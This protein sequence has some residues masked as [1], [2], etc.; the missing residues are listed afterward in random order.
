M[1]DLKDLLDRIHIS[2]KK[3]QEQNLPEIERDILLDDLRVLYA[4]L[5]QTDVVAKK[6]IEMATI[7]PQDTIKEEV[8]E[9]E[10]KEEIIAQEPV[11]SPPLRLQEE[12]IISVEEVIHPRQIKIPETQ[13]KVAMPLNEIFSAKEQSLNEKLSPVELKKALNDQVV[14]NDLKSLIDFNKQIAITRELFGGDAAAYALAISKINSLS[15]IQQ[16][17]NFVTNELMV[18]FKWD[19]ESQT[20]R[21]FDKLLRQKFGIS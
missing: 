2:L 1:L 13:V 12:V 11:L 4:L 8:L 7:L 17:F 3:L 18:Q 6:E 19:K 14:S 10:T 20:V 15:D 5:K 9:V 21:L 16:A